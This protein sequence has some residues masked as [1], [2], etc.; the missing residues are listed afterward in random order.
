MSGTK[1]RRERPARERGAV[2]IVSVGILAILALMAVT[3]A[4]TMRYENSAAQQYPW[5]VQAKFTARAGLEH[6]ITRLVESRRDFAPSATEEKLIGMFG[7]SPEVRSAFDAVV[8]GDSRT[9]GRFQAGGWARYFDPHTGYSGFAF[10]LLPG[11]TGEITEEEPVASLSGV[12]YNLRSQDVDA[13][14]AA[15]PSHPYWYGTYGQFA[16]LNDA[17]PPAHG[18]E[19][20]GW[21]ALG[22]SLTKNG[23]PVD[24]EILTWF[25]KLYKTTRKCEICGEYVNYGKIR[26]ETSHLYDPLYGNFSALDPVTQT[27][28]DDGDPSNDYHSAYAVP[29][30][31]GDMRGLAIPFDHRNAAGYSTA[32][33]GSYTVQITNSES[34]PWLNAALPCSEHGYT[35]TDPGGGG[36]GNANETGWNYMLP[37]EYLYG[38]GASGTNTDDFEGNEDGWAFCGIPDFLTDRIFYDGMMCHVLVTYNSYPSKYA[39]GAKH[40]GYLTD[41]DE[42]EAAQRL[43]SPYGYPSQGTNRRPYNINDAPSQTL[44]AFG[45]LW[46][47]ASS[48][49]TPEEQ[50]ENADPY[51][52][53]DPNDDIH[54]GTMTPRIA[55]AGTDPGAWPITEGTG[56]N[57][58]R[59]S[60]MRTM[61]WVSTPTRVS[62]IYAVSAMKSAGTGSN[63]R[64]AWIDRTLRGIERKSEA[65]KEFGWGS[66]ESTGLIMRNAFGHWLTSVSLKERPFRSRQHWDDMWVRMNLFGQWGL[67]VS[68]RYLNSIM[69]LTNDIRSVSI[70]DGGD[71]DSFWN[72]SPDDAGLY[73][74][75]FSRVRASLAAQ[76]V[77]AWDDINSAWSDKVVWTGSDYI[78]DEFGSVVPFI[79]PGYNDKFL[80]DPDGLR[81][82]TGDGLF[83]CDVDGYPNV[84][85]AAPGLSSFL[86]NNGPVSLGYDGDEDWCHVIWVQDAAADEPALQDGTWV[87]F[88][89]KNGTMFW[90]ENSGSTPAER[91]A[92]V[93]SR[94]GDNGSWELVDTGLS[95]DDQTIVGADTNANIIDKLEESPYLWSRAW[96][97]WAL[98]EDPDGIPD[99]GDEIYGW[100]YTTDA[101]ASEPS[102]KALEAML[103][104]LRLNT[105]SK[106]FTGASGYSTPDADG[107]SDED[108]DFAGAANRGNWEEIL[109]E[110]DPVPGGVLGS[111]DGSYKG[112]LGSV[113]WDFVRRSL[114]AAEMMNPASPVYTAEPTDAGLNTVLPLAG[115]D[116]DV[117]WWVKTLRLSRFTDGGG[118]AA[119]PGFGGPAADRFDAHTLKDGAGD[120]VAKDLTLGSVFDLVSGTEAN[121]PGI[122]VKDHKYA[123]FAQRNDTATVEVKFQTD[124]FRTIVAGQI[125]Y[126]LDYLEDSDENRRQ[127]SVAILEGIFDTI[128]HRIV[129]FR[130][131][132]E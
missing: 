35:P 48:G 1:G 51:T 103:V 39:Y 71:G 17:L 83:R 78:Y 130:W 42:Y 91:A 65:E 124:V 30:I 89:A 6:A 61:D 31:R 85:A 63:D 117:H 115:F 28:L 16:Q 129:Y 92:Y 40:D 102:G 74:V 54:W 47:E 96:P 81:P 122:G 113:H 62:W 15:I 50:A 86:L 77:L 29:G 120:P 68:D 88:S 58:K 105:S 5:K 52:Y 23:L 12:I 126:N 18:V 118:D 90:Q 21:A 100:D 37:F 22:T 49:G 114:A 94:M 20:A 36:P 60:Y 38:N 34:T 59:S 25:H 125:R 3:F 99:N 70:A 75:D 9:A 44:K 128:Q 95:G 64:Y 97:I 111:P 73:S 108:Y 56:S 41:P 87:A 8:T 119:W 32:G 84:H 82:P 24:P 107:R 116:T 112:H 131:L 66:R 69:G 27:E 104:G 43:Y 13:G 109:A 79:I 57:E 127:T 123:P 46:P 132:T 110:M 98:T 55:P 19:S 2:L 67:R 121:D 10:R 80:F 45:I 72:R 4:T 26:P 7:Q 53:Y 33:L 11:G 14:D 93:D 76:R 101:L 106:T